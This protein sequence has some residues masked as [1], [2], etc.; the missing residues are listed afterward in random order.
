MTPKT[1]ALLVAAAMLAALPVAPAAAM[2]N[3]A[4]VY[5]GAMGYMYMTE[6]TP[7][8]TLGLC[9]MP[10]GTTV[11]AWK[12]LQGSA[13]QEFSYCAR[14]GYR[15]Q[16]VRSYRTCGEFGLG[17][18]LVCVL[19]DGRTEEVT[20]LMNLSFAETSCGDRSCGIPE[21]V[22]SCPA[23]CTSGG[24]DNLCDGKRDGRCDPDCPDGAGDPDCGG[25]PPFLLYLAGVLAVAAGLA[26]VYRYLKRPRSP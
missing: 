9:R 14:Q 6:E 22:L 1:V 23:D 17:E 25:N 15:Q 21:N 11:D 8:G 20:Q 10:G 26:G 12:F 18:C 19:P 16:V 4:A 3:P 5:C 2:K 24:W 7:A 13:G